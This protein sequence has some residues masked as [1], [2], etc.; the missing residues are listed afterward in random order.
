MAHPVGAAAMLLNPA[1]LLRLESS[2]ELMFQFTRIYATIDVINSTTGE[3]VSNASLGNNRGPYDLPEIAFA[4]R[5]GRW[6]FGTGMFAAGGFGV[7]YGAESFLSRTTTGN[8]ETGLPISSRIAQMRIPFAFAWQADEQW[9]VGASLD[10]VSASINLASLLDAQQ[11]GML[12]Q[13]GRA[14]GSLVPVLGSIPDLAGAHL[15]FVKS[16]FVNSELSAWGVA[17]RLAVSYALTGDTQLALAYE[18]RTALSDL[19]GSGE[20]TAID[21]NNNQTVLSGSGRLPSLQFPEA[22]VMGISHRFSPAVAVVADLRRTFWGRS[23]GNI[24]VRFD[25]DGGGDLA[26]SLPTGFRH[27][28]TLAL[29]LE[30]Q[31]RQDWTG[32]LGGAHVFQQ[33]VPNESLNGAFPTITREHVTAALAW[34]PTPVHEFGFSVS[35][36]FTDAVRNPG[37][38]V[39]S[40]PEIE[41]RNR[42]INPALSYQYRL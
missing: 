9:S 42:Q 22:W 18:L 34:R 5:Q 35:Y 14:T 21:I 6:A 12:I 17:G 38:N 28:T 2:R 13:S 7:E 11:L 10:I 1:E 8:V 16:D 24:D 27:L 3:K 29:G 31:L 30:W 40:I 41:A 26:V 33:L 23:F 15:N 32:R 20:T 19:K 39:N 36:G 4:V 37:G 25:A